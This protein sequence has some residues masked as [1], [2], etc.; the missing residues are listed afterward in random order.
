MPSLY[1]KSS[2]K[3]VH[4]IGDLNGFGGTEN[5]LLRYLRFTKGCLSSHL[6]IVLREIGKKDTVGCLIK[7]AGV[8]IVELKLPK[9][10]ITIGS[11]LKVRKIIDRT[12]PKIISSW[13][14]HPILFSF[15]VELTFGFKHKHI[16]HIRSLPFFTEEFFDKRKIVIKFISVISW[17]AKAQIISNSNASK[18]AHLKI[19][20]RPKNWIIVPNGIDFDVFKPCEGQKREYRENFCIPADAIVICTIGRFNREKGYEVFI[21]A[22]EIVIKSLP[23][24]I[25]GRIFW[26]GVGNGIVWD[27]KIIVNGA[28]KAISKKNLRLLGIRLDIAEILAMSDLYVLPSVSESFPNSLLEAMASGVFVVASN[29][30]GVVEIGLPPDCLAKVSDSVD[31]AKGICNAIKLG[32]DGRMPV[33]QK[34]MEIAKQ[35]FSIRSM[36]DLF[37]SEYRI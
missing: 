16:W 7:S 37:D 13:L 19:G 8:A 10:K 24:L 29:V 23:D 20:F 17:F 11:I 36:V 15:I 12:N 6:V 3:I 33:I 32:S 2:K 35:R 26:V 1:D 14:Y 21:K 30:G 27:N 31:L 22:L 28:M 5:V 34:N 9:G 18:N 25:H 4:I